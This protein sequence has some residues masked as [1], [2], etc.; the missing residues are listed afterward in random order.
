MDI[1]QLTGNAGALCMHLWI[2]HQQHY[3]P[4]AIH[5]WSNHPQRP[6]RSSDWSLLQHCCHCQPRGHAHRRR[7]H[8]KCQCQGWISVVGFLLCK[9]RV[10]DCECASLTNRERVLRSLLDR[11]SCSRAACC[12]TKTCAADGSHRRC[13]DGDVYPR[14]TTSVVCRLSSVVCCLPSAVCCLPRGF[15]SSRVLYSTGRCTLCI[16][17]W[18]P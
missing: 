13:M 9:E 5:H 1:R 16:A 12:M 14:I 3:C 11:C 15:C 18:V 8:H 2:L 10:V 4:S 17:K 6:A 7:A